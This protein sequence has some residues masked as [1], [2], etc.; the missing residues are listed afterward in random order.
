MV[1]QVRALLQGSGAELPK[2]VDLPKAP[3][4][5]EEII[6]SLVTVKALDFDE[7][8]RRAIQESSV[9]CCDKEC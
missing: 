8:G 1:D 4:N 7:N 6:G 3:N 9:E 2:P 5:F